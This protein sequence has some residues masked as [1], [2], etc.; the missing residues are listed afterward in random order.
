MNTTG[1]AT[2]LL[3]GFAMIGLAGCSQHTPPTA[4]TA[5]SKHAL[6]DE[7]VTTQS[8]ATKSGGILT[9][10]QGLAAEGNHGAAIPLYRHSATATGSPAAITGLAK[11]LAALGKHDTAVS[12]LEDLAARSQL[13]GDGW[14]ILG[15]CRLALGKFEQA[16]IAFDA[17]LL[18]SPG[19][20]GSLSARGI[21]LA[22]LGRTGDAIA[23][24]QTTTDP[25]ALS[26]LALIFAVTGKPEAAVNIL[27]PIIR[28]G[29]ASA[30]DRQ[31]L[32]MAYLLAGRKADA[33]QMARLDL[34]PTTI[35]E[36]FTFYRSLAS[37][38][39]KH[40]MQALITGTIEPE[41]TTAEAGNLVLGDQPSAAAAAIRIT[42]TTVTV[43]KSAKAPAIQQAQ[44]G[45]SKEA[46]EE[47]RHAATIDSAG[48]ANYELTEVPP[49]VEPGGWAL[50]IGAYRTTRALMRG[51]TI[52]YRANADLLDNI[53]PRRSEVNFGDTDGKPTGFYHRLNAGPLKS[54]AGARALCAK[55]IARGTACWVRPPEHSEQA[56][57]SPSASDKKRTSKV[58]Q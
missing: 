52:L 37:M 3:V 17:A 27:A 50:Q 29:R 12:L 31:N 38:P 16:L 20:Q 19:D 14:Y 41:W 44:A 43:S 39:V 25:M 47:T 54:L 51:W 36:T 58:L 49:L 21:T 18:I 22:A 28:S 7:T 53:P 4:G 57:N 23:S 45:T 40:R 48:I 9:I 34:D 2:L 46:A 1:T 32:A 30:H 24:Y 13:S 26:N 55:L 35:D 15:K 10:A 33:W 42:E 5:A 56:M 11:S 8:A 6:K